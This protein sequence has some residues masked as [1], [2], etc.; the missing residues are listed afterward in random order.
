[1]LKYLLIISIFVF[2]SYTGV[3]LGKKYLNRYKNLQDVSKYS[4]ILQNEIL[5][6]NTPLPEAFMELSYRCDK[7]FS[8]I[9]SKVSEEL[10]MGTKYT[11]YDSFKDVYKDVKSDF[12]FSKEDEKTISDFLKVLG[13][14]GI[15]GQKNIFELFKSNIEKNLKEAEEVSKKNSKLYSYLGVLTGAMVAIFLI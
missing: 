12:Y 15:Y 13:E 7:S 9:F 11:A 5:Y 6:K 10:T 2:C 1:M 8:K 14:S 3:L 4:V